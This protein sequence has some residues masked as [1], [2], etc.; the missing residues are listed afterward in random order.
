MR[1]AFIRCMINSPFNYFDPVSGKYDKTRNIEYLSKILSYCQR[2]N[3]TVLYGEYN[4][5]RWEMKDSQEWIDMS[6]DYLYY[7]VNDLGFTC[8]KYFNLFNEPDGNWSSTN[9]NFD[10]WKNMISR[11]TEKMESYPG[12]S[13]KVKIAGP[14]VVVGYRNP[15]SQFNACEWVKQSASDMN[16]IIG[17]YDVHAYPGQ[18]MVRSG[19]FAEEIKKYVRQVPTGKKIVLGEAGYKYTDPEDSDLIDK[20]K[21]RLLGN[22]ITRG[23][24]CNMMVYDYFYGLDMP[25]LCMEV[26]NNGMSGMS[27]WMLD[28]A[29]HSN[30]DAGNKSDIKLWGMWNILGSE[31]FSSVKEEEIRPWFYSWVLMCRYFPSGCDIIHSLIEENNLDIRCSASVKNGKIS[32]AIVNTGTDDYDVL[33]TVPDEIQDAKIFMYSKDR[34]PK[35]KDGFP[36]PTESGENFKKRFTISVPAES[37]L[38][39][40]NME[41]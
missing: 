33:V 12:L 39:I 27:V 40:T 20:Q 28:D 16:N 18:Y 38:L 41:N 9:G 3:I 15:E 34:Q 29:M 10:L 4:P 23:S 35:D 37:L 6:V 21:E 22:K 31:V 14:D 13:Q 30:G 8:I 24:D 19:R 2:N 1:P 11:Y 5:P 17:I 25:L 32:I 7:L 26:M 36:V